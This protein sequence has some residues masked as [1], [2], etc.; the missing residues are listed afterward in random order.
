MSVTSDS[1]SRKAWRRGMPTGTTTGA[2]SSPSASSA[3]A[4]AATELAAAPTT[5]PRSR[6]SSN[7]RATPTSSR[8][9]PIRP[10]ASIERPAEG[11]VALGGVGLD[12]GHRRVADSP[13]GDVDDAFEAHLVVGI[14]QGPEVGEDVLHLLAVVEL[15]PADDP[16]GDTAAD[17]DL[18]QH[19]ALGVGPVEDRQV[20]VAVGALLDHPVD[21][22]GEVERLVVLVLPQVAADQLAADGVGPQVLG[23]AAGVVGDD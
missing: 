10:A 22:P 4:A 13:L 16:V 15:H 1:A 23:T 17:E 7:S 11:Q 8:R 14:G 3:P 18:L 9:F 5:S 19:P 12:L 6:A 2:A 20:A 21:L